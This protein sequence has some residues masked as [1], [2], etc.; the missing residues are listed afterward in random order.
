MSVM[1]QVHDFEILGAIAE[2][3]N[4]APD[5][6]QAL[7]RSLA[8]VADLLGLRT[9]WVW[10]NDPETGQFYLAGAQNLPPFLQRPVE[11]VGDTCTCISDFRAGAL[12]PMN[13]DVIECSRLRKAIK[14]NAEQETAGLRF[15]ASIPL[16]FQSKPLGIMNVT[17]PAWR[18]LNDN[19]LRLLSTI[20]YQIGIAIERARLAD[21]GA[22][23]ARAEERT[24]LAR[25]IHDTLAQGL[26]AIGLQIEGAMRQL[27]SNPDRARE[28][29]QQALVATREGLDEA[30]RA[31]LDLRTT[32]LA[33]KSLGEALGALGRSF[34]SETGVRV[35]VRTTGKQALPLRYEAELFRI[36]QE[37]LAN[38]RKHAGARQV[39]ITLRS[40]AQRVQLTIQDDGRGFDTG[41]PTAGHGLVGM[42]ERARLLGGRLRLERSPRRGTKVS[43][44]LPLA[45]AAPDA[46]ALAATS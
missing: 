28:R 39:T 10:L 16:S 44:S 23:F 9:G 43:V 22:R 1:S 8:L 6:E 27:E 4:R 14:A 30:R 2:A 17:G 42:E 37:A 35:H 46:V 12:T 25:E 34:T 3:L 29:L 20:A 18:E 11:M 7:A 5:V 31:V 40:T 45:G 15:H 41:Q 36:A 26:T 19:E 21:A 13:V 24:R 33:G 32:P 38:V